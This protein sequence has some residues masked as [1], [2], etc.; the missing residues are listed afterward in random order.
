V[1]GLDQFKLAIP[2]IGGMIRKFCIARFCRALACL[3]AAG[4]PIL[5]ALETAAKTCGNEHLREQLAAVV[6]L[7]EAGTP[8][9]DAFEQTRLFPSEV[10]H[11]THAG[12]HTGDLD[13]LLDKVA[14]YLEEEADATANK[15]IVLLIP[16]AVIL[17]GLLVV[18]PILMR[19][20]GSLMPQLD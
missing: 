3:Y 9:A 14:D 11:M 1:K 6:P 19:F 16:V 8:L 2:G 5:R 4:V 7:V 17:I 10:I 18:L 20:Y 15:M 13:T 12:S